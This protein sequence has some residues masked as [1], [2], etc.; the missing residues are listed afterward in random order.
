[1]KKKWTAILATLMA[2]VMLV[3]ASVPVLADS[4]D[5][6]AVAETEREARQ[7]CC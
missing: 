5:S 2:T 3:S 1:M 6:I 7:N 4:D